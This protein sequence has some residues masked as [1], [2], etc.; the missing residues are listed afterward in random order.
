MEEKNKKYKER[1]KK[2]TSRDRYLSWEEKEY[3]H[4]GDSKEL[5]VNSNIPVMRTE[6][7]RRSRISEGEAGIRDTIWK[8]HV[9]GH[10]LFA[11][12]DAE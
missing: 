4:N 1:K 8:G 6:Q 3:E 7:A 9:T 11:L 10:T 2:K 5:K 12:L